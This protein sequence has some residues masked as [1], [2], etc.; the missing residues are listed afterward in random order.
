MVDDGKKI[1][2]FDYDG[3]YH[4]GSNMS[5][6][7]VIYNPRRKMGHAFYL[8]GMLTNDLVWNKKYREDKIKEVSVKR[9][10]Y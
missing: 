1:A 8:L 10:N 4:Y 7:D 5:L 6:T 2:L 3:Y 9:L